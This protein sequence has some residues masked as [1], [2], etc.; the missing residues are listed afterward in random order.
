MRVERVT[1]CPADP[2]SMTSARFSNKRRDHKMQTRYLWALARAMALTMG[3]L[4]P[5][6]GSPPLYQNKDIGSP[7][8]AGATTVD[9]HGV[10]TIPGSGA[11]I[12]GTPDRLPY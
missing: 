2:A 6:H 3:A 9:A 7:S 1:S 4:R 5:A 12:P 11:R 10:Y 8:A